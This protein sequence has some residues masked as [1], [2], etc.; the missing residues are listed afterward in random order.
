M[1]TAGVV[2]LLMFGVAAN[3]AIFTLVDAL[4]LR[5]LPVRDPERLVRLVTLRPPLPAYCEFVY[6]QYEAWKKRVSG[7]EDLL[8]WSEHDMFVTA[9]GATERVR[10][11]FVTDNFFTALGTAPALGR[12]LAPD[13]QQLTAGT[14]PV[15]LSYA[16][17]V[18][19]FAGDPG[20]VGETITVNGHKVL[21][22]GVAAKGFN[23]LT[24][25][26]GPD[27]RAPLGWLRTLR[28]DLYE[29]KIF[30]EVAG[31]LRAGVAA[32]AVRQEADAVWRSSWKELNPTD[33]GLPGRFQLESATRGISRMRQQLS[34]VLWLL[35]GGVGLFVADGLRE[36]RR[37]L[38]SSHGDP[39]RRVGRP[40]RDRCYSVPAGATTLL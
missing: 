40:D 15:V 33:P 30:C 1:F 37:A 23:G 21:I 35:M 31:R 36:R 22:A 14:A 32:E 7:F 6:E 18:R 27:L 34:D 20:I 9:G 29:N 17:W 39:Q 4:L 24:V 38:S 2:L 3:T 28:P 16:Y 5:P 26:T 19:R 11:H 8:A 12:L 10:V 13:D 25:E